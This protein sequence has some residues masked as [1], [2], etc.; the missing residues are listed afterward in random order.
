ML[1]SIRLIF[2]CSCWASSVNLG[3]ER[4]QVLEPTGLGQPRPHLFSIQ[5][6]WN[7]FAGSLNSR[8]PSTAGSVLAVCP[9]QA[10]H[11]YFVSQC[12]PADCPTVVS[13]QVELNRNYRMHTLQQKVASSIYINS[14][15]V[16]LR[17][18]LKEG[19]YVI[20]P[21][22]FDPGHVGEFLLRIFTD[23]PSDCR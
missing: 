16:F 8:F 10:G 12:C 4:Q 19:R 18:D 13:A 6:S 11:Q 21:T 1:K 17:T 22:T 15:S 5:P 2:L 9:P 7:H 14:R 3:R 23:V 20:I